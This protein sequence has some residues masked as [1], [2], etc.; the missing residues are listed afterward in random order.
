[1]SNYG[2]LDRMMQVGQYT[3]SLDNLDRTSFFPDRTCFAPNAV[4]KCKFFAIGAAV[5][6]LGK[7]EGAY[8]VIK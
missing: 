8:Y 3:K 1:M 4:D 2:V 5:G 7:P 6:Y